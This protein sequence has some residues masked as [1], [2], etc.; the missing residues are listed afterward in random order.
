MGELAAGLVQALKFLFE[1]DSFGDGEEH[2]STFAD[3][4]GDVPLPR[5]EKRLQHGD[6]VQ[7]PIRCVRVDSAVPERVDP[8]Q[9]QLMESCQL[10]W[11]DRG[12]FRK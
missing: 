6:H 10:F 2:D 1:P 8:V 11:W 7:E 9:E 3:G 12:E 4:L 5:G